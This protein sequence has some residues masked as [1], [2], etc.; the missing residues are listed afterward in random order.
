MPL[1]LSTLEPVVVAFVDGLFRENEDRTGPQETTKTGLIDEI[2]N[3]DLPSWVGPAFAAWAGRGQ[4]GSL[5]FP[6]KA[7]VVNR[8]FRAAAALLNLPG[9]IC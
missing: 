7:D 2:I 8:E 3:L 1:S 6:M 4:P 5:I 9:N